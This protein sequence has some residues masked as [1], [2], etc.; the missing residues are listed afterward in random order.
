MDYIAA[1]E[2]QQIAR[3]NIETANF[4]S[5]SAEYEADR[6]AVLARGEA[7]ARV[8]RA[9]GDAEAVR[10]AAEAEA[11]AI[12]LRGAAL[13]RYPQ[14][15]QLNMIEALQFAK[16]MMLPLDGITPLLQITE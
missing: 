11:D 2:Q 7:E 10:V 8:E 12:E 13:E 9:K 16:W 6:I 14:V 5:Q 15:L 3:E 1:I 4:Q